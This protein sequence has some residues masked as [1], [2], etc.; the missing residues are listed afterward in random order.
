[1]TASSP[2]SSPNSVVR[3]VLVAGAVT[4][5]VTLVRLIGELSGW[6]PVFFSKK[7]GGGFAL[8]G[9]SWLVAPFGFWFGRLIARAHGRPRMGRAWLLTL[10]PIAL[11]LGVVFTVRAL[12]PDD[13]EALG[14]VLGLGAPLA[15]L[16][17]LFAW[18]R[19][20]GTNLLYG[21]LARAP[22]IALTYIAVACGWDTH[23][24]SLR[25]EM[26]EVPASTRAN[27]LVM[28]QATFWISYTVIVGGLFAL[29][30][31]LSVRGSGAGS[32]HEP[33]TA[34]GGTGQ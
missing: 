15:A 19:A 2:N 3:A 21:L 25:A 16:V 27:M 20:F 33:V 28:A 30:G 5:I 32:G 22:V 34:A 8:V 13:L 1:M 6:A 10:G 29:L 26:G 7:A 4:L 11:F 9:I 31:A 14:P 18:P 24:S 17:A 23:F 12:R